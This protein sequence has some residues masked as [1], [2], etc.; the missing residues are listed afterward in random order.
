MLNRRGSGTVPFSS[1]PRQPP[2]QP[3][4]SDDMLRSSKL[5]T[6]RLTEERGVD[7]W[8]GQ[9]YLAFSHQSPADHVPPFI[10]FL[11]R[12]EEL[13]ARKV[14]QLS[15]MLR[16]AKGEHRAL[17]AIPAPFCINRKD[18]NIMALTALF[19]LLLSALHRLISLYQRPSTCPVL[20]CRSQRALRADHR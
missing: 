6:I 1:D 14:S 10:R 4:I 20:P 17:P 3:S 19:T 2:K 9:K 11:R 16:E 12:N 13:L 5:D 18:V 15:I 8:M 7:K